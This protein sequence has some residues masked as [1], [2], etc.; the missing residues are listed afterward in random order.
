[1]FFDICC[2]EPRLTLIRPVNRVSNVRTPN[3][4]TKQDY[5]EEEPTPTARLLARVEWTSSAGRSST[6]RSGARCATGIVQVVGVHG[7]DVLV[8]GDFAGLA[9]E[10]QVGHGWDGDIG[11]G[12]VQG[13]TVGPRA[14]R[15]VL[16]VQREG[17]ILEVGQAC[18]RGDFGV[19]DSAGL[20][21]MLGILLDVE[22]HISYRAAR[23]LVRLPVMLLII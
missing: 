23:E 4:T 11:L 13:K 7:D 12:G 1:M 17:F 5:L 22:E 3:G 2:S 10:A 18:L 16:Q 6:V 20:R 9:G 21:Q 15:L 19:A 8:V 14:I